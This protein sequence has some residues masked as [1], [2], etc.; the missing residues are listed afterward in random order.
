MTRSPLSAKPAKP[1]M[2]PCAICRSPFAKR[3]SFHKLCGKLECGIAFGEKSRGKSLRIAAKVER[4]VTRERKEKARPRA[5][6]LK[7]T[8]SVVNLY[9]RL[10]DQYAGLG[11][12]SCDKPANWHG[13]WHASHWK[14]VGSN[15]ALRYNLWNIHRSCSVCNAHLS[16]NIGPYTERL[17]LKI[18]RERLE[19]LKTQNHSVTYAIEYLKRMKAVFQRKCNRMK[20]RIE[21][22]V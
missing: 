8:E 19:W 12:I 21:R 10:R 14:S 11:C 1:K 7:E 6:W 9:V 16:G 17:P 15:S 4:Q 13:Q 22:M 3:H 18:G 5:K 20:K 2:C